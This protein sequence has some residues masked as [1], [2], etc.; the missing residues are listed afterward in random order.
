[1][2]QDQEQPS[3]AVPDSG[4]HHLPPNDGDGDEEHGSSR[5]SSRSSSSDMHRKRHP[6]HHRGKAAEDR[7][8]K[9]CEDTERMSSG[10]S[11]EDGDGH[12]HQHQQS[13]TTSSD[14]QPIHEMG[15]PQHSISRSSGGNL[16]TLREKKRQSESTSASMG[17][18]AARANARREAAKLRLRQSA[19][20]RLL[21]PASSG[22]SVDSTLD[23]TSTGSSE[24][25]TRRRIASGT[26]SY[27]E[28]CQD[29]DNVSISS[30]ISSG[31]E[32]GSSAAIS[33]RFR[34]P[35]K[36]DDANKLD[37]YLTGGYS[38]DDD[39]IDLDVRTGA[40]A[41]FDTPLRSGGNRY[42]RRTNKQLNIDNTNHSA[43]TLPMSGSNRILLQE[44]GKEEVVGEEDADDQQNQRQDSA[45]ESAF[46][47]QEPIT[48]H[49]AADYNTNE[50]WKRGTTKRLSDHS[51]FS[52]HSAATLEI[53]NIPQSTDKSY[54]RRLT[55]NTD[56]LT[57]STAAGASKRSMFSG[58]QTYYSID[59]DATDTTEQGS[60]FT[61]TLGSVGENSA[62]R[63]SDRSATSS[64]GSRSSRS[65]RSNDEKIK[66]HQDDNAR[67]KRDERPRL[68]SID[69]QSQREY[70]DTWGSV[71]ENS[72]ARESDRSAT[73][74][75]GSRSSR[76]GRSKDEKIKPHQD[77]NTKDKRVERAR[78][79][80]Q[81]Q[82]KYTESGHVKSTKLDARNPPD[83]TMYY[84]SR[85]PQI[86]T[87]QQE[88]KPIDASKDSTERATSL[89]VPA[90]FQGSGKA[91][92]AVNNAGGTSC[93]QGDNGMGSPSIY[94][95]EREQRHNQ[96]IDPGEETRSSS[97]GP[98]AR[99][100]YHHMWWFII[101]A[102]LICVVVGISLFF[103][104][105]GSDSSSVDT[106]SLRGSE[107]DTLQD[108][109]TPPSSS[110]SDE[111]IAPAQLNGIIDMISEL[112]V[113]ER[114]LLTSPGTP[115]YHAA[116]WI[117]KQDLDPFDKKL[118]QPYA[119]AVFIFSA[120]LAENGGIDDVLPWN[121]VG[122][123]DTSNWLSPLDHCTWYGIV[124]DGEDVAEI[125]LGSNNIVG[126][127]IPQELVAFK[128]TLTVLDLGNSGEDAVDN[129]P[130]KLG[131][132]IPAAIGKLEQLSRLVLDGNE[133]EGSI[134][135]GIT[136]LQ[137]LQEL[138]L[139]NN[140]MSGP[141]PSFGAL[142]SLK[143]LDLQANQLTGSLDWEDFVFVPDLSHIHVGNNR[144]TGVLPPQLGFLGF[145]S[146]L[147]VLDLSSN[148]ISGTLPRAIKNV[149]GLKEL[150]LSDNAME[151]ELPDT[152]GD[153]WVLE[154]LHVQDND[155]QGTMPDSV[156]ELKDD[157]AL[158][159]LISDCSGRD[160]KVNC[161]CCTA[162]GA[163]GT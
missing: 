3:D 145:L 136:N 153:L 161:R 17:S 107:K 7:R 122:W 65:G 2:S 129:N 22:I 163:V 25:R 6:H 140:R 85:S 21:N 4:L 146:K 104:N 152:L 52:E 20:A 135:T 81:S 16:S 12:Q 51:A 82:Q 73:S 68:D 63:E 15:R 148:S 119:L 66:P 55:E 157:Y 67:D 106:S 124:C 57:T 29:A 142:T 72:A 95:A 70:T 31:Y 93:R 8:A 11:S 117:A 42:I 28:G 99:F 150:L 48:D 54:P 120:A 131:G 98:V 121:L 151:G 77:D 109:T 5:S 123:D 138:R 155:F 61:D 160:P 112:G 56:A 128:D 86:E 91:R 34:P 24:R 10:G 87:L 64:K 134:P 36:D 108:G 149:K 158:Q 37:E 132:T 23:S 92:Q 69:P 162:C 110:N 156:C 97:C 27:G 76:S 105:R 96:G 1:M 32:K 111:A 62:A 40:A 13:S 78:L 125:N 89:I 41:S 133:L 14:D 100:V 102:V 33:S 46:F 143:T 18:Y 144:I 147:E 26:R 116:R 39:E 71:D 49:S 141:V 59:G 94:G 114:Q 30:S 101:L 50:D 137:N 126:S 60:Q 90:K 47:L 84:S 130:N 75:K 43:D 38:H 159:E 118:T 44:Q 127:T 80:P 83:I 113:S 115:Q 19:H 35:Y 79:D 139:G 88:K 53:R 9:G 45:G 154:R 103:V 58:S 74:S